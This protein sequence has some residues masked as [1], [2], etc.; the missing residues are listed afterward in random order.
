MVRYIESK[1]NKKNK[2]NTKNENNTKNKNTNHV[3]GNHNCDGCD[4]CDDCDDCGDCGDC[5]DHIHTRNQGKEEILEV[6]NIFVFS[7]CVF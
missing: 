1:K 3:C 5:G 7:F 4:D 6:P 2:N